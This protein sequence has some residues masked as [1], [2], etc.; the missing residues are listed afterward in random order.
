MT[1][2]ELLAKWLPTVNQSKDI[3]TWTE[4]LTLC[5]LAEAAS[6]SQFVIECG[7]Y[8]GRSAKV[9]L[10]ANP[11]LVLYCIDLF[12]VRGEPMMVEYLDRIDPHKLMPRDLD[13]GYI[14][15]YHSLYHEAEAGRCR[16]IR[17][18]SKSALSSLEHVEGVIDMVFVDDGHHEDDVERDIKCLLPL[19]RQGGLL[20]GHDWD[21]DNDVAIGVKRTGIEIT[22]PV[23]RLWAHT[24][25]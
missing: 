21:G 9:M 8:L 10:D 12:N 19:L 5:Y 6:K 13:T 23:P 25:R 16:L 24:K 18:D 17:G 20:C 1:A 14:C 11:R 4:L 2:D 22:I 15:R 7:T 3:P